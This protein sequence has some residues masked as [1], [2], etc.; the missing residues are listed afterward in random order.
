MN[1]HIAQYLFQYLENP[2]PQ[3]AVMLKG[4]WGCGKSY[5]IQEWI[6]QYKKKQK[7]GE[8]E[9]EPIYVSLYGLQE[10]S[11]ITK[12]IDKVLHPFLYTKGATVAK[13]LLK[14]AGNIT[15]KT[16][17]DLANRDE[18]SIDATFDSLSI[19]FLKDNDDI[20]STKL[21]I[22]DDFERCLIEPKQ[23]LGYIN[24]FVEHGACHVIVIG[25]ETHIK[26][27]YK[28]QLK[29]FKEKTI[30][31]EF[32]V[33]T[34]GENALDSFILPSA[35]WLK[36]QKEFILDCF[37]STKW[38]NL[39]ILRQC[40]Y[41]FSILY[42]E[43]DSTLLKKGDSFMKCLLGSYI[44]TYCEFKGPNR[45]FLKE[46]DVSY[47]FGDD[48]KD[49]ANEFQ[50]KYLSI[51]KKYS[52]D[53]FN[54]DN[55]KVIISGIETGQSLKFYV[56]KTLKQINEEKTSIERLANF[57]ALSNKDFDETYNQLEKEIRNGDV[58]NMYLLGRAIALLI[59]FDLKKIHKVAKKTI[60]LAK[61]HIT[62]YFASIKDKNVLY[63]AKNSFY[64]GF[65]FY[66]NS[67]DTD[68]GKDIME[69]ATEKFNERDKILK[70]K[71]EE[72]LLNLADDN[73]ENLILL[74]KESTPNNHSIYS[75]TSIF[76]NIDADVFSAR[77]LK[78]NNSSL[79]ALCRFFSVHYEF[80]A[81][82]GK[83]SENYKD[84]LIT[85]QGV[86][87]RLEVAILKKKSVEKY[88]LESL[89]L[90]IDGAIKRA[91]G[92]GGPIDPYAN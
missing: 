22:F 39:R 60:D 71:M 54:I 79:Q 47:L 21:I 2:D 8:V 59:Y 35:E 27:E 34:D 13:K 19:L 90:Y 51:E 62:N 88:M 69:F 3:Y 50:K 37:K 38:D 53:I 66:G 57:S 86:K 83:L 41:D 12:A 33:E 15:F 67:G 68:F 9:I 85:L 48:T 4:K 6:K 42:D 64:Q 10:V 72:A 23:L 77:I 16:N 44:L 17:F 31:R 78:L 28:N 87:D 29:E 75:M 56:E 74:S 91:E 32:E 80:G 70:N 40:L 14:L 1:E 25:D 63:N 20:I 76:K 26:K 58:P 82:L 89:L 7:D 11:Q 61:K 43:I 84:D 73:V 49:K 65:N 92:E 45:E 81:I 46:W 24:K 52:I 18:L 55:I 30:G 5:F 36:S